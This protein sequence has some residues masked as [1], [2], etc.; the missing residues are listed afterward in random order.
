M[1][2]QGK[3]IAMANKAIELELIIN[4]SKTAQINL[5]EWLRKAHVVGIAAQAVSVVKMM[6]RTPHQHFNSKGKIDKR[7]VRKYER[8]RGVK[9]H[10][11]RI[12]RPVIG[13]DM[14]NGKDQSV[15]VNITRTDDGY[16]IER[17]EL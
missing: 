7:K 1:S 15:V 12:L 13:I 3:A 14:S 17:V 11:S 10:T 8:N 2:I 5:P 9:V 6:G 4:K 16:D